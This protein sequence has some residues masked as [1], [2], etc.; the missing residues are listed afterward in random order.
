[1]FDFDLCRNYLLLDYRIHSKD[2]DSWVFAEEESDMEE[3]SALVTFEHWIQL[4]SHTL[5]WITV[6]DEEWKQ[7]S[8]EKMVKDQL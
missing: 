3:V 7:D 1:M 2:Y 6:D 8:W 5:E 4:Q